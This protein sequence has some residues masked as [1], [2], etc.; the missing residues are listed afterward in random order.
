MNLL[1]Q[2]NIFRIYSESIFRNQRHFCT[3][4][5]KYQKQKSGKKC[6][7]LYQPE[8]KVPRNKPIKEVKDLYLENCTA[9]KIEIKKTQTNENMYHVHGLEELI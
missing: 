6:H 8:N 9:L 3:T 4:T 7:I 2:H 5:R 1:K